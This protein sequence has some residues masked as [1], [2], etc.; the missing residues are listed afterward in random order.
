MISDDPV[1]A[2]E[3][4]T[5]FNDPLCNKDG[6]Q[7]CVDIGAVAV[8]PMVEDGSLK[9]SLMTFPMFGS[10]RFDRTEMPCTQEL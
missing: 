2:I 1:I 10:D 8:A 3:Q 4:I 7:L 6:G 9:D 5:T